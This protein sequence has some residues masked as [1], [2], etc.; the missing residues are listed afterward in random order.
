MI[1]GEG[2]DA[3]VTAGETPALLSDFEDSEADSHPAKTA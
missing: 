2:E 3:L 1:E